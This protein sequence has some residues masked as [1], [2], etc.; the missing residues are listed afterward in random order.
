MFGNQELDFF[1]ELQ[2]AYYVGDR[3]TVFSGTAADFFM[4]EAE[5]AAETLVGVGGF[6]RIEVFALDILDEGKLEHPRIRDILD[7]DG[8][9][10]DTC[11]L[12]GAP[13][14]LPGDDLIAFLVLPNDDGLNNAVGANG[15]RQFLEPVGLKHRP[16]LH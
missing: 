11:E 9:L 7:D 8:H 5:F 12:C 14:A 10:S 15:R 1:R 3:S 13:S 16:G 4:R 2:E 6:D